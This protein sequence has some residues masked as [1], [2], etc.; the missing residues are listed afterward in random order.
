MHRYRSL[1]LIFGL[2]LTL[3]VLGSITSLRL[4]DALRA[5]T[6]RITSADQALITP[7]LLTNWALLT[8]FTGLIATAIASIWLVGR[9]RKQTNAL[10]DQVEQRTEELRHSR[11]LLRIVFDNLPEGLVLM[12][13]GGSV[14]AAN[15]AFCRSI[16]GRRPQEIVGTDYRMLWDDLARQSDLRLEPQHP[17]EDDAPPLVPPAGTPLAAT[18]AAWR[19]LGTDFVGQQ[20]WY[21]VERTPISRRSGADHQFLE[22]WR[23]ITLHEE[24]Q[25]RMLLHEQLTSLGRLA[26]S[27]AH[28]VGNPLQSAMSC[29]ELCREDSSLGARSRDYLGLAL[30]ELERM[31]RT[32]ESLRN[33]YRPP[34]R[35]WEQVD[36]NVIAQ[37]VVHFT[38]RQFQRAQI[39]VNLQLDPTLPPIWGQP[40]AIR[41]VLL[42]LLLN[43]QEALPHGGG[44]ELSTR[45]KAT[46]RVC[47]VSIRDTGIGM[48]PD[49]I[50]HAF[51]PFR[52]N[53]AQG[54]GLGLAL[55]RQI[56][57]QHSGQITLHS[58]V[59]K[60]TVVTLH[61][62]WIS[63]AN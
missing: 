58:T 21:A 23:D 37:Q 48:T 46:D 18:A 42:N 1:T 38:Q 43:A 45:R 2:L 28:E 10:A 17:A 34:Q 33:L 19:V 52:S 44:I 9:L 31:G 35:A 49:Q 56:L 36:L 40:D 13:A 51:E 7:E 61:I 59:G 27:V 55:S 29:L 25:R 53:K 50:S 57:E 4:A 60:G 41:Q 11:D 8:M 54:V 5:Q 63:S 24:L 30:G 16:V 47:E 22:R 6:A 15:N 12:N 26:A 32:L 62:P 14:L 20:R 39:Q 3:L